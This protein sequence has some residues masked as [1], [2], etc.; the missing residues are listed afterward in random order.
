MFFKNG[1][2]KEVSIVVEQDSYC[3]RQERQGCQEIF[4]KLKAKSIENTKA[5]CAEVLQKSL[6]GQIGDLAI[7]LR[8]EKRFFVK[9]NPI[10]TYQSTVR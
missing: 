10:G 9:A 7:K 6:L 8:E 2:N 4:G 5:I 1:E 3:H